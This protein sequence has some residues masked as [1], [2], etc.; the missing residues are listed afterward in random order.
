MKFLMA[1]FIMFSVSAMNCDFYFESED[2]C[3]NFEWTK[4]PVLNEYSSFEVSFFNEGDSSQ[5]VSP[6]SNI[7]IFTWMV[8]DNGHSHGGPTIH[9]EEVQPGVFIVD[10]A[11][12]FMHGMKGHWLVKMQLKTGTD[13]IEEHSLKV[14]F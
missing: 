4:G 14:E 7:N 1:M 13:L 6:I 2:L 5:T 10:D 9:V 12:F 11:K 3:A 8:M